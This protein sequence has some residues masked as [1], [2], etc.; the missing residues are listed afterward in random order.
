M[1]LHADKNGS[2]AFCSND[3]FLLDNDFFRNNFYYLRWVLKS[4]I[5]YNVFKFSTIL[6]YW[7]I[8]VSKNEFNTH[9]IYIRIH[10]MIAQIPVLNYIL[11]ALFYAVCANSK[12]LF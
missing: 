6:H 8:K 2:D 11:S 4:E 3:S 12:I 5:L 7:P 10:S 9:E 1:T